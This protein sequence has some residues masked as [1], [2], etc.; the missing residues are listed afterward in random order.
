VPDGSR[1]LVGAFGAGLTWGA[2]IVEWGG[3]DG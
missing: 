2:G 3:E 1:I